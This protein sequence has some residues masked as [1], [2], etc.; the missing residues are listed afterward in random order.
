MTVD[1]LAELKTLGFIDTISQLK[2]LSSTIKELSK[3]I[4]DIPEI[5]IEKLKSF[6]LPSSGGVGDKGSD[7]KKGESPSDILC[8]IKDGIEGL[9][10]DMKNGVLTANVFLD[11]QTFGF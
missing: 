4:N 7:T 2:N 10:N 6:V 3:A 11:S 1:S 9:R 5:K 8:A